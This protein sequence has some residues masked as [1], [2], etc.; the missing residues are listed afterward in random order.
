[1]PSPALLP[2]I[3]K[4]VVSESQEAAAIKVLPGTSLVMGFQFSGHI[5]WQHAQ[6]I[7]PLSTAGVT[8]ILHT[9]RIFHQSPKLG[10]ILVFF[11]PLAAGHFLHAP[12]G[13]L[14]NQSLSLYDL[15]PAAALRQAQEKLDGSPTNAE[16][17][18]IVESLL[19]S[20]MRSGKPDGMVQNAWQ[21]IMAS[22]G[23]RQVSAIAK[24]LH[25]SQR[26]LERRFLAA[27]GA[28]PKQFA[29]LVRF[30]HALDMASAHSNLT[31]LTYETGYA[32]QSHFIRQFR[33]YTGLSPRQFF[34]SV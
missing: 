1:M 30:H 6:G 26:Q 20:V 4:F 22:K 2:Y 34:Q 32:D 33:R 29:S 11:R 27:A 28:S 9:C 21:Q 19:L 8:G 15:L 25:I 18:R 17:V 23:N 16:R 31:S 24:D 13:E 3:E 10:S 5:A 7:S 14:E 12:A